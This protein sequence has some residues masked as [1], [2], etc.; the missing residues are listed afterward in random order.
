[1]KKN[2]I[3]A[4]IMSSLAF[5]V[6]ADDQKFGVYDPD[7]VM[8]SSN[9][10]KDKLAKVDAN[11]QK[12]A[13]DIKKKNETLQADAAKLQA[14]MG[15]IDE[16]VLMKEKT[17]LDRRQRTLQQEF[18]QFQEEYNMDKQTAAMEYIEELKK[19]VS[20]FAVSQN[21]SLLQPIGMGTYA[22]AKIDQTGAITDYMN[23]KYA[24]DKKS[25]KATAQKPV[26]IAKR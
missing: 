7:K 26:T 5:S 3:V 1:M 14:K 23:K 10:W 4:L 24:D 2:L 22:S 20:D 9:E 25:G 17:D 18:A 13:D 11:S 19:A 8:A 12:K 15:T 21:F 6:K 16:K